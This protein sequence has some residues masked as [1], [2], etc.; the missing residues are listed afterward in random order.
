M[1]KKK[2][3][4]EVVNDTELTGDAKKIYDEIKHV[5]LNLFSLPGQLVCDNIFPLP[6]SGDKLYITL[7]S[8]AVLTA[9]EAAFNGKFNIEQNMKYVI[10]SR[11]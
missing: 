3:S 9:L 8:P 1:T 7:K 4:T 5:S 11:A 6:L 10:I 2:D